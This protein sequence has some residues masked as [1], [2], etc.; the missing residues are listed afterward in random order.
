MSR[1][2]STPNEVPFIFD[3]DDMLE[4]FEQDV[5]R[6]TLANVE[7]AMLKLGRNKGPALIF[8]LHFSGNLP[9]EILTAVIGDTWSDAEFPD[10]LIEHNL[11]RLMF[12]AAGY[13]VDGKPAERPRD[14]LVLY[15][16]SVEA[17]A[18]DWSWT[19]SKAIAEGYANGTAAHRPQGYVF[20]AC[21]P[22]AAMLARNNGRSESEY[23]IDTRGLSIR[24]DDP[25][26]ACGLPVTELS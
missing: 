3:N 17:R 19:D 23:V 1:P 15:R 14:A 24:R 9:P 21:V 16:G 6:V 2:N 25:E 26:A 13:T 10:S 22:P 20:T 5:Y 8:D 4:W 7:D 12:D 18:S 11:W